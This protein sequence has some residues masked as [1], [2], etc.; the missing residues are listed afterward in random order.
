VRCEI[1]TTPPEKACEMVQS[2]QAQGQANPISQIAIG[3]PLKAAPVKAIIQVPINV[4]LPAGVKLTSEDKD[5]GISVVYA[6][7]VPAA[8]F[9]EFDLKDDTIKKFRALT[10]NGK[11][12]IKDAAQQDVAI[13]VS[14]KG[15]AQAY[16]AMMKD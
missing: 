14:F 4:W 11:L 15:F 7:C 5:P 16:D 9:A 10:G 1:K 2:T 3:K 8:C 12:Q 6:R 13:P